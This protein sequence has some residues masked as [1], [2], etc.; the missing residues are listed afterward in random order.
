ML[1]ELK[2]I[3]K[4]YFQG[5]QEM[6]VLKNVNFS[7]EE[8]EY[9]A[10]MGPSGSGKS[11]LM[12][13]IGCLDKPTSGSFYLDGKDILKYKDNALSTVRLNTIGFVFQSFFLMMKQTALENVCLPL[14]YAGIPK[15]KRKEIAAQALKRVGLEDR[16][17]YKPTQLSGGQCQRVAIARAISNHPKIL[18]ADEP[19]GNLDNNNAWEIMKLLEEINNKGTTV[20]V[21]THNLEIV[22]VMKKRVITVKKGTIVSDSK[23]GD[24]Y[25]ED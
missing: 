10:I 12:N 9:V 15:R 25:D 2:D 23:Q 13:I 4:S 17:N 18:L 16:M 8:G 19:T 1:L 5:K 14:T 20:L 3:N 24:D 6:P 7:V 11:T 21:V 22:K